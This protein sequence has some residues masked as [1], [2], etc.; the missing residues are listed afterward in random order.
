MCLCV[1]VCVCVYIVCVGMLMVSVDLYAF[2]FVPQCARK[3][4]G[5]LSKSSGIAY[6]RKKSTRS[7]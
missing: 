2:V 3:Q 6:P 4:F 5:R 1:C 7:G